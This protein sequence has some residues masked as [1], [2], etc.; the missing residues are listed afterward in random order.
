MATVF[1]E[2]PNTRVALQAGET[3]PVFYL[4][5]GETIVV[6]CPGSGGS[7][8]AEATWSMPRE[9]QAGVAS[10]IQWDPGTV[11]DKASQSLFNA[12]ALRFTAT[13]Q[14]GTGEFRQ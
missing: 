14:P 11:T 1:Q 5:V 12:T 8:L 10:W 3:S 6:A 13:T 4:S 9:V 2:P 7:M